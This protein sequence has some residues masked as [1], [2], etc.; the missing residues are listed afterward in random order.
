MSDG[1]ASAVAEELRRGYKAGGHAAVDAWVSLLADK[2]QSMGARDLTIPSIRAAVEALGSTFEPPNT[3]TEVF[4]PNR[5]DGSD[6]CR[7]VTYN[8]QCRCFLYEGPL[9]RLAVLSGQ[10]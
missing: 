9:R 7:D 4:G 6:T 5:H 2:A 8:T 3:F 10:S 1:T